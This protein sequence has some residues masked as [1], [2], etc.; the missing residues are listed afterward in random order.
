MAIGSRVYGHRLVESP[1]NREAPNVQ[2]LAREVPASSEHVRYRLD[3]DAPGVAISRLPSVRGRSQPALEGVL[4]ILPFDRAGLLLLALVALALTACGTSTSASPSGDAGVEA[5]FAGTPPAG[6]ASCPVVVSAAN[7]DPNTRPMLFVHGTYSSGTDIE[8][9][10]A[11]LGSNGFCQDR[12]AAIDYD[13]VSV[14]TS[15]TTGGVDSPG[16]DCTAPNTPPGC[17]MIDNA[18]DALLAKYPQFTQVDLMG[19]SQ[20][21]FHCGT[22]LSLHANKV[23]HYIN[24]SGVPEVGA[25]QTL[26]L[27]SLRDLNLPSFPP[28]HH[29]TGN[30]MCAFQLVADGGLEPVVPWGL[31]GGGADAGV[32]DASEV[33]EA[34]GGDGGAACNVTQITLIDQDHFA[35]AASKESFIQV[36]KYL[37][38]N[39]P[40]YTDIQ[41]GDD[42]VTVE[43][44]AETFADNVPINGKVVIQPVGSTPRDT[45]TP[46]MTLMGNAD[47]D[48]GVPAGHFGPVQLTRNQQYVFTGY[49]QTGKLV[50]WQYFTPFKRDNHLIRLLSPASA[51]DG[52]PVGG[53]VASE[54][55]SHAVTSPTTTVVVARWAEGGIRQDLGASLMVNGTEVLSS[56]NSGL[57]AAMNMNLQGGVAAMFL[58]DA[59]KNGMTDLGLP[60]STTFIAFTDVF[61][62]AAQPAFVNMTFTGGSEDPETLNVPIA[63]D[64]YPSSQGFVAVMF[65]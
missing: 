27:S 51:S 33:D 34:D 10:A 61:I 32:L 36:Y 39:E 1:E 63:V 5:G 45:S 4:R 53:L 29:A 30:S 46:A 7:C 49:D 47:D 31:T 40:M 62:N 28:P 59:N 19:H 17:G 22:Y 25:V 54:S 48:A 65:Q 13:S 26:S 23:A 6:P 16:A 58:E 3:R 44:I 15:G 56:Q 60:Y 41:C 24:F 2:I 55:T 38:G 52:S 8:H 64:N 18:I 57:V 35:V 12:I 37:T 14:S 50:G 43:G 9:M 42:P 21:T 11:L 20:G